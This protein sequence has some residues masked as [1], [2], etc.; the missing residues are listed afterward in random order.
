MKVAAWRG[1]LAAGAVAA[2]LLGLSML[3]ASETTHQSAASDPWLVV[4]NGDM[5]AWTS[6]PPQQNLPAIVKAPCERPQRITSRGASVG[7]VLV[8]DDAA[9]LRS[10]VHRA[11][12]LHRHGFLSKSELDSIAGNG[13]TIT[14]GVARV[15]PPSLQIAPTAWSLSAWAVLV[16]LVF[17][18]GGLFVRGMRRSSAGV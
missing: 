12:C 13:A 8:L 1:A 2:T 15:V 17:V 7:Q 10:L 6:V 18:G 5:R 9:E 16:G 11:R 4:M 14:H 3:A